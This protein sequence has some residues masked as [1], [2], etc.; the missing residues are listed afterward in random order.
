MSLYPL[1]TEMLK[2][3]LCA[4]IQGYLAAARRVGRA[5]DS[6]RAVRLPPLAGISR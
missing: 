4:C 3:D 1:A 2:V 5:R 6:T